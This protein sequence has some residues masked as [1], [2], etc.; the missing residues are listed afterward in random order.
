MV[1]MLVSSQPPG[2]E[3]HIVNPLWF[4]RGDVMYTHAHTNAAGKLFRL[5]PR[6]ANGTHQTAIPLIAGG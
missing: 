2:A 6:I 4:N 3:A 1:S 5:F